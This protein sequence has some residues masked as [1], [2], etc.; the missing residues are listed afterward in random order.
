MA[1]VLIARNV[2]VHVA[3]V[4][5]D[6]V[7]YEPSCASAFLSDEDVSTFPFVSRDDETKP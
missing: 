5:P 2:M 4:E 1:Q 3:T 6:R 7:E